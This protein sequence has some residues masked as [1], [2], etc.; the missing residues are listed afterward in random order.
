M[1]KLF[2]LLSSVLLVSLFISCSDDPV[3]PQEEHYEAEGI[4]FFQSGIKIAEIFRGVTT[5]TLFVNVD[6]ISAEI[7]VKFYNSEQEIMDPPNDSE[8]S[9]A[10][11]IDVLNIAEI[12]QTPGTEGSFKFSLKGLTS[13]Y[14]QIEFFIVHSGHADF[15]SGKITLTVN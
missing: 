11:E 7:E 10:W 15:R 12:V 13:G 9:L 8:V 4:L 14:T 1:R 6:S 2:L 5:D 3:V